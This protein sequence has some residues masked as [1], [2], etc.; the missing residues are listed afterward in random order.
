[1]LMAC[2][3]MT[4]LPLLLPEVD[5][6]KWLLLL[7]LLPAAQLFATEATGD[8]AELLPVIA[9]SNFEGLFS[10]ELPNNELELLLLLPPNVIVP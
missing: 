5:C 6:I 2:V 7:L 3:S 9:D 4:L 10:K 8:A 1:M